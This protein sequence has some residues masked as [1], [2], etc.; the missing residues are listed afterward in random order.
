MAQ[1]TPVTDPEIIAQLN[2]LHAGGGMKPVTDQNVIDQLNAKYSQSKAENHYD[3]EES[4]SGTLGPVNDYMSNLAQRSSGLSG[5]LKNVGSDINQ[6]RETT[7]EYAPRTL[8]DAIAGLAQMGHQIIN[9]P[10]R[11]AE[12]LSQAGL[13]PPESAAKIPR[14]QDYDY[15]SMLGV[16]DQN[17]YDKLVQSASQYG[18]FAPLGPIAGS[19]IAGATQSDKPIQGGEL[20]AIFGAGAKYA[21]EISQSI[22]PLLSKAAETVTPDLSSLLDKFRP[23]KQAKSILQDLGAGK[24]QEQNALSLARDIKK[25]ARGVYNTY[26]E[27]MNPIMEKVGAKEIIPES[28]VNNVNEADLTSTG[29]KKMNNEFLKD[30]TFKN[31]HKLQSQYGAEIRN[32]SG[33]QDLA[34]IEKRNL[35]ADAQRQIKTDMEDFLKNEDPSLHDKYKDMQA[36]YAKNYS[37]YKNTATIKDIIKEP[38]YADLE[39]PYASYGNKKVSSQ[40]IANA[41]KHPT[42]NA[43]VGKI[44]SDLQPESVNKL[45]FSELG[46]GSY[47]DKTKLAN[48]I[49]KLEE[50]GLGSYV[51]KDV[52][53]SNKGLSERLDS[54]NKS[55]KYKKYGLGAAALLGLSKVAPEAVGHLLK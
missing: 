8:Q 29:L 11:A 30:P 37:P 10:S 46:K 3:N 41:L 2:E 44:A 7:K 20:G 17:A 28:Y 22:S 18:A 51:D 24:T 52:P 38:K 53:Y 39:S 32:L 9:A 26:Q 49:Q 33:A 31:A 12:E 5:V 55:I 14:Q 13:I 36:Y 1:M 47:S 35:Y 6:V 45:L 54:L 19:I 25:N 40:S 4:S 34:S 21:P 43:D 48:A 16:K 42:L 23:A 27:G 15:A 50:K